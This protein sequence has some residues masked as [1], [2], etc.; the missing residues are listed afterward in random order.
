MLFILRT[1]PVAF[2]ADSE[3]VRSYVLLLPEPLD[4]QVVTI[5]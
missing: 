1:L 5:E 4:M 2:S 3:L